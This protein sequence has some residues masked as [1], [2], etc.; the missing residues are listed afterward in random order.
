MLGGDEDGPGYLGGEYWAASFGQWGAVEG[1]CLS[2]V[3]AGQSCCVTLARG[4]APFWVQFPLL[5][6][7][8]GVGWGG[9]GPRGSTVHQGE[10][11]L[12]PSKSWRQRCSLLTELRLTGSGG[13]GAVRTGVRSEFMLLKRG[14]RGSDPLPLMGVTPRG[15]SSRVCG[16]PAGDS[17]GEERG[18]SSEGGA[19]QGLGTG[20]RSSCPW[21]LL[22]CLGQETPR[23][24][25]LIQIPNHQPLAP[26]FPSDPWVQEKALGTETDGGG[27]GLRDI[28]GVARWTPG[29]PVEVLEQER[30]RQDGGVSP[31]P[32]RHP[33]QGW[34]DDEPRPA[35]GGQRQPRHRSSGPRKALLQGTALNFSLKRIHCNQIKWAR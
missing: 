21:A 2:P 16:R 24:L 5:S 35:R 17:P 1:R 6:D 23:N 26:I 32:L 15:L 25:L 8:A 34:A 4:L 10:T 12:C 27:G 11:H 33:A 14:P 9:H 29:R 7:E 19:V 20:L 28:L 3:L 13:T 22:G 30:G 31:I 18:S